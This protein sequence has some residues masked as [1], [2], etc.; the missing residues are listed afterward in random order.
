[1]CVCV[2][3]IQGVL[4]LHL[5]EWDPGCV[6]GFWIIIDHHYELWWIFL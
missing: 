6:F 3:R 1:V 2:M 5:I 4:I